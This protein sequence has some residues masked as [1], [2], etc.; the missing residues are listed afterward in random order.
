MLGAIFQDA[1]P[2]LTKH[3]RY[4]LEVSYGASQTSKLELFTQK[5]NGLQPKIVFAK[6]FTLDVRKSL[7]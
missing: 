3:K 5:F 6:S 4:L 1:K 7:K 2:S